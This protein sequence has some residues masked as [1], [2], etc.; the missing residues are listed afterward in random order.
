MW[1][2][3]GASSKGRAREE[4]NQAVLELRASKR[5]FTCQIKLKQIRIITEFAGVPKRYSGGDCG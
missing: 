5:P 1:N 2:S 4:L 3:S